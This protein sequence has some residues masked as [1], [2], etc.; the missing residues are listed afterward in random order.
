MGKIL[1][2]LFQYLFE[3]LKECQPEVLFLNDKNETY[4]PVKPNPRIYQKLIV[5]SN[6]SETKRLFNLFN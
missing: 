1:K 3:I 6:L 2:F 4:S 5:R